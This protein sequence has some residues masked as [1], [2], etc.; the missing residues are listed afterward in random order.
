MGLNTCVLNDVTRWRVPL[1]LHH[2]RVRYVTLGRPSSS[3]MVAWREHTS[4]N[5]K[6]FYHGVPR[7]SAH[8]ASQDQRCGDSAIFPI[9]HTLIVPFWRQAWLS[10]N[11]ACPFFPCVCVLQAPSTCVVPSAGK[12]ITGRDCTGKM[13]NSWLACM[14]ASLMMFI[15]GIQ[16]VLQS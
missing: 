4:S 2:I 15:L 3:T 13:D 16:A 9:G 5:L 8:F 7:V 14:V 10:T 11:R 12:A 6:V 1:K